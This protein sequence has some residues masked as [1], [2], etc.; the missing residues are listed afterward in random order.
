M[1]FR[2]KSKSK[3]EVVM[4][5]EKIV[6]QGGEGIMLRQ[7]ASKYIPGRSSSLFKLKVLL[8]ILFFYF[9]LLLVSLLWLFFRYCYFSVSLL[10]FSLF[11]FNLLFE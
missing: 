9:I 2:T 8:F 11:F 1:A 4:S 6:E 10:F 5:S 7:F 3:K